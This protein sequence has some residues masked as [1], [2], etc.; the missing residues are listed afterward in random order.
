M[1][2]F[3][4]VPL[5]SPQGDKCSCGKP[6]GKGA[7]ECQ[8]KHPRIPW[9][10]HASRDQEQI[11][12]WW[13]EWPDAGIGLV[14]GKSGF[15]VIDLDLPDGPGEWGELQDQYGDEGEPI[16][17]RTGS[18][19]THLLYQYEEG[20]TN[21]RGGLGAQHIDVRGAGGYIV[22]PPSVHWTGARYEG[23][24]ERKKLRAA[25]SWVVEKIKQNVL[26]SAPP[27]ELEGTRLFTRS[28][29][30]AFITYKK[31]FEDAQ[32]VVEA[33]E[34]ILAGRTWAEYG[35]RTDV[36]NK[37]MGGL[38]NFVDHV[39]LDRES[40]YEV[41]KGTLE[42]T[43]KLENCA[44]KT[45]KAWFFRKLD[46]LSVTDGV[47][48]GKLVASRQRPDGS[49][50]IL[51]DE[52]GWILGTPA[53]YFLRETRGSYV[54]PVLREFVVN[55][56]RDVL[57]V[58]LKNEEG[59][60]L[61]LATLLDRYGRSLTEVHYSYVVERSTLVDNVFVQKVGQPQPWKA[62]FNP[63]IAEWLELFGGE[64]RDALLD[65]LATLGELSRPT[66]A[67][68]VMGLSGA[69]K[70][71]LIDGLSAI[72]DGQRTA[73]DRTLGQFNK[74]LLAS[75]LVVANEGI[76]APRGYTGNAVDA[77]KELIS[78]TSRQV[79]LK[80]A[81][82]TRLLG[83]NR[84]IMATNNTGSFKFDRQ[85][86]DSDIQALDERVLLV[87]PTEGARRFLE[88]LG[89]REA[90][91]AWV[92][93]GGLPRHVQW[94]QETRQVAKGLRFLVQGRGGMA[95]LLGA[96]GK[97]SGP[98]LRALLN[99]LLDKDQRY[100]RVC[101]IRDGRVWVSQTNLKTYWSSLL[102]K[103]DV[104]EDFGD[105]MKTLVEPG[106]GKALRFGKDLLGEDKPVKLRAVRLSTL[107]QL[108]V[109]EGLE[110]E[111]EEKISGILMEG[112]L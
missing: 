11:L 60:L 14:T 8:A 88:A 102:S 44:E 89:G 97:A 50:L 74:E 106:S 108:A 59:R 43:A 84:V 28:D 95:E 17:L 65:W 66:A 63:Q 35:S 80:Y 57:P 46:A 31:R 53:G 47:Y 101:C 52:K 48:R 27:V 49:K 34:R 15:F 25:P 38:R 42:A 9:Q 71:L 3:Y 75:P 37:L 85:L 70:D 20:I 51:P 87:R 72:W 100:E 33:G 112:G 55:M 10:D 12:R 111:L 21:S 94:L 93:G 36:F 107:R 76:R 19:G 4:V 45:D 69:G 61:P 83:A 1:E 23:E 92:A 40:L 90:T 77:L 103:V 16:A 82:P 105:V 91:D 7:G 32:D 81:H 67:L 29:M 24:I 104:P 22:V 2:G 41:F 96:G 86:T 54:G 109:N 68:C 39:P 62:E 110:E 98:V 64:H 58:K 18:G 99:A 26:P 13:A 56:A 79:E 30:E 78:N 5:H 73:F 6:L